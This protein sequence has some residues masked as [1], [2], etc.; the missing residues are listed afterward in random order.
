MLSSRSSDGAVI[1]YSD[2]GPGM[3]AGGY[4]L[5]FIA[6]VFV[7]FRVWARRLTRISLGPDDY[8]ILVALVLEHGIMAASTVS[9]R[10]GGIGKDVRLVEQDANAIVVLYKVMLPRAMIS[11][12]WGFSF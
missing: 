9:I 1:D 10:V 11:G 5:T 8:M 7:G 3:L 4:I 12:T 6:T 2:A